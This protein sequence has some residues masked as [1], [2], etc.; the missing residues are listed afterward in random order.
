[1]HAT[2]WL[3]LQPAPGPSCA[4]A[5]AGEPVAVLAEEPR[6]EDGPGWWA[7][8]EAIDE[9]KPTR[10][11]PATAFLRTAYRRAEDGTADPT[12]ARSTLR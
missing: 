7:A 2:L 8:R 10:R 1:M 4:T 6:V 11:R 3:R 5:S 12:R 9:V